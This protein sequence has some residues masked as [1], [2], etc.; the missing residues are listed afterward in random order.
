MAGI[1]LHI[2]FC[3]QRCS[4]CDFHFSVNLKG[5]SQLVD[6]LISELKSRAGYLNDQPI[7][8]IYF[9]G[10]TPSL[11]S[12]QE[13]NDLINTIHE[14]YAVVDEP[15]VTFECN[16][17]DISHDQ[18]TTWKKA[19]INRLSIGIQ[20]FV[21]EDLRFMKRAHDAEQALISLE[22]AIN[23]G[24]SN[25]TIDLIFGTPTLSDQQ[26]IENIHT[27]LDLNIP[28]VSIYGLTVEDKTELA[29]NIRNGK[30]PPLDDEQ[31]RRQFLLV[32]KAL[33]NAGYEQYEISNYSIPGF[34]S[35]HNSSYWHGVHYLGVGPSAHSFNGQSRSWNIRSNAQYIRQI[36]I[37]IQHFETEIL[38]LVDQFNEFVMTQLRLSTGINEQVIQS[39]YGMA[40]HNYFI[41]NANPYLES[42][43]LL[44]KN[45]HFLLTE[46]GKLVADKIASDLF[47]TDDFNN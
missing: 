37:G 3:K 13:L 5:K 2:P 35:K 1:Y 7:K 34:H 19:G 16:P 31:S 15:E 39:K 26:L 9:G 24:F 11:L 27:V 17:D 14:N 29:S 46:N 6:A 44:H 47:I 33:S 4:Y 23:A 32:M 12:S 36:E 42:G 8:T 21:D 18:L 41:Q 40:V 43:Q 22:S 10:G 30:I 28:H 25:I 20:S 38:S 45:G